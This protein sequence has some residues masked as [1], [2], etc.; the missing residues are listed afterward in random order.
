MPRHHEEGGIGNEVEQ[1]IEPTIRAVGRPL[2]QL[3][4]HSQYPGLGL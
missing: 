2:V 3:C 4:L 1:V